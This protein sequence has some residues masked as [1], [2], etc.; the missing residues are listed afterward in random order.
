MCV[1]FLTIVTINARNN[2]V[3]RFTIK[4]HASNDTNI[5]LNPFDM[6][7]I[8]RLNGN[9]TTLYNATRNN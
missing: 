4:S 5:T 8:T 3:I 6:V 9:E 2:S 7:D 1:N